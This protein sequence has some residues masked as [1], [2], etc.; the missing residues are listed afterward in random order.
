MGRAIARLF[1]RI[2]DTLACTSLRKRKTCPS[3]RHTDDRV[4]QQLPNRLKMSGSDVGRDEPWG[5]RSSSSKAV[6]DR[7]S[8]DDA[9]KPSHTAVRPPGRRHSPPPT[10]SFPPS[11]YSDCSSQRN[12]AA[13]V[14]SFCSRSSRSS[15][16]SS[17]SD[18]RSSTTSFQSERTSSVDSYGL[19]I[20]PSS[21]Y[22]RSFDHSGY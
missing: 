18:S 7:N 5:I 6:P 21:S 16:T 20:V 22:C 3:G 13:S 8:L 17:V 1:K 4:T 19:T 11:I 12:S 9:K 10:K 14:S 15:I 2:L